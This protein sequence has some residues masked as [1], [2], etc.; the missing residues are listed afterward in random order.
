MDSLA[1][2]RLDTGS[3]QGNLDMTALV[4]MEC[5]VIMVLTV[6]AQD[7]EAVVVAEV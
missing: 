6:V 4:V 7:M 1:H 2:H 3:R 5:R